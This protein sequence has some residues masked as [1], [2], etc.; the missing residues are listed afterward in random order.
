MVQ[1]QGAVIERQDLVE[2]AWKGAAVSSNALDQQVLVIRKSL[3]DLHSR[4][5]LRAVYG[6]G[7]QLV[8]PL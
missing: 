8:A 2:R 7:F 6:V 1:A 5:T 3:L 4:V